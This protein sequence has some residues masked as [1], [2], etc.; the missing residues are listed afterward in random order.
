[1]IDLLRELDSPFGYGERVMHNFLALA[2]GCLD[3]FRTS[4]AHEDAILG[5]WEYRV[6]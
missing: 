1:M 5:L 2:K 6:V 3:I 4:I